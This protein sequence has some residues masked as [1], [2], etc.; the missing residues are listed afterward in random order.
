MNIASIIF[1]VRAYKYFLFG[2]LTCS[3]LGYFDFAA[4]LNDLCLTPESAAALLQYC[5]LCAG[6]PEVFD[7]AVCCYNTMYPVPV[8]PARS[9]PLRADAAGRCV[10]RQ[11]SLAALKS[12]QEIMSPGKPAPDAS[13]P[14]LAGNDAQ[15]NWNAAWRVSAPTHRADCRPPGVISS[16]VLILSIFSSSFL[17][18]SICRA[19]L[20]YIQVDS[21]LNVKH[22]NLCLTFGIC[23][24]CDNSA[25]LCQNG[26]VSGWVSSPPVSPV[27]PVPAG[28]VWCS[29]G[30]GVTEPPPAGVPTTDVFVPSQ[31]FLTALVNIFPGM[32]E[33]IRAR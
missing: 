20:P 7:T 25:P 10:H 4:T 13:D 16:P 21:F 32:F 8:Y 31:P 9:A 2:C 6:L 19:M 1:H 27:A 26:T 18:L 29:I 17:I 22:P 3:Y 12:F 14:L 15:V 11:V 24:C 33:H 23:D 30:S 28:Q 5:L